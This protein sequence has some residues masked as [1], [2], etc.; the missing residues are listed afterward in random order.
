M[1]ELE[2]LAER[3]AALE[4]DSRSR[5]EKESKNSFMD[6]YGSK[7]SGDEGIGTAILAELNR[8]GVDTSA[9]DE[10]VQEIID[11]LR[12]EASALLDKLNAVEEA[13]QAALG[14]DTSALD[15]GGELPP[16]EPPPPMPPEGGELPPGEMLS[17]ERLKEGSGDDDFEEEVRRVLKDADPARVQA[18]IDEPDEDRALEMYDELLDELDALEED[19][20]NIDTRDVET[21][22]TRESFTKGKYDPYGS[23]SPS[24]ERELDLIFQNLS[25]DRRMKDSEELD[26]G[27]LIT[28]ALLKK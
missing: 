14:G 9:A 10:A 25:S 7:F 13:V 19:L 1:T 22:K 4:D 15:L 17:D 27:K 21:K 6:K 8:R 5:S 23:S 11:A 16:M 20:A 24:G 2:D 12:E 26:E 28:K 18:I 3:L